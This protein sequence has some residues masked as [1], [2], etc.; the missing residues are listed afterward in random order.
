M[1]AARW[2]LDE[3]DA[4]HDPTAAFGWGPQSWWATLQDLIAPA[5]ESVYLREGEAAA[6]EFVRA[7]QRRALLTWHSTD[8]LM[9][10][11]RR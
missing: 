10:W 11:A 6:I 7:L 4:H 3:I 8:G 5:A 2:F 1:A 9:I